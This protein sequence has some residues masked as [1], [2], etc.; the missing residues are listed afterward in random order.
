MNNYK[1][2]EIEV[3]YFDWADVLTNSPDGAIVGPGGDWED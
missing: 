2:P 3:I 1:E